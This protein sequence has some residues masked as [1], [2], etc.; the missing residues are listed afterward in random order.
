VAMTGIELV[1]EYFPTASEDDAEMVLWE[2]TGYPSFFMGDDPVAYFRAQLMEAADLS[3]GDPMFAVA[4]AHTRMDIF[5]ANGNADE[6]GV[7]DWQI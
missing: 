5:W 3:S 4:I 6:L 7:I 1:K 2:C